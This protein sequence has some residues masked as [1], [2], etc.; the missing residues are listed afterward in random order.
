MRTL[1][2][3]GIPDLG[4]V[5]RSSSGRQLRRCG[6]EAAAAAIRA[7]WVASSPG[8]HACVGRPAPTSHHIHARRGRWGRVAMAAG[9]AAT[10]KK[11]RRPPCGGRRVAARIPVQWVEPHRH[12]TTSTRDS[13]A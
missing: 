13:G 6:G 5:G 11:Q 3:K 4:A 2:A 7:R 1:I 9:Y 10:R 8:S 12:R